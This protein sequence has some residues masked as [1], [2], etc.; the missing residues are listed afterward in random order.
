MFARMKAMVFDKAL[1]DIFLVGSAV[2]TILGFIGYLCS[3]VTE[4]TPELSLA[5]IIP[6]IIAIV[7]DVI[8]CLF[9]LKTGKYL[10]MMVTVYV[11]VS[12][13]GSQVNLITNIL[14]RIDQTKASPWLIITL[15]SDVLAFALS[16]VSAILAKDDMYL[17][18][19][20]EGIENE[21]DK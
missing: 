1:S 2:F 21:K 5:V 6:S 16:L 4:F 19:G 20:V 9:G 15:V 18:K 10:L 3:G 7:I 12:Y 17:G 13:F 8:L 11:L 14:L